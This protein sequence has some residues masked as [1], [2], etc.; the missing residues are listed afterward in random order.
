M[1]KYNARNFT[2]WE[3][4]KFD[5]TEGVSY[6]ITQDKS[7]KVVGPQVI[8]RDGEFIYMPLFIGSPPKNMSY[9]EVIARRTATLNR[10]VTASDE[11]FG[12]ILSSHNRLRDSIET[13]GEEAL[14][15]ESRRRNMAIEY[16]LTCPNG[17]GIYEVLEEPE[18]RKLIVIGLNIS[19]A[20][21][22]ESRNRIIVPKS[23]IEK[24]TPI[25]LRL[26]K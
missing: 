17:R 22:G 26:I 1:T 6:A 13:E 3:G 5:L 10:L 19:N 2:Q 9:Q 16:K 14:E 12:A 8:V 21:T 25:N 18:P 11:I 4:Q 24:I 23:R 20:Q 7:R 15:Q